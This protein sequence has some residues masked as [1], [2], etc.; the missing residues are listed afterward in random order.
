ACRRRRPACARRRRQGSRDH[1]LGYLDH[2]GRR[3]VAARFGHCLLHELPGNFGTG[4]SADRFFNSTVPKPIHE[5]VRTDQKAVAWL[6]SDGA[7]LWLDVLMPGSERLLKGV[8]TGMHAL[9]A[10]VDPAL[11]PQPAH[12]TVVVR[13]LGQ[14]ARPRQV[15]DAA[16]ADVAKIHP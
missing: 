11:P 8:A 2:Q 1:S 7:D 9:F 5:A 4:M 10:F 14:P 3:I 6:V 12:V 15:V 16:V 13:E